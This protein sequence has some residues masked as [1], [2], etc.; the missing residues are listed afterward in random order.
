LVNPVPGDVIPQSPSTPTTIT[1]IAPDSSAWTLVAHRKPRS[2]LSVPVVIPTEP[3]HLP[4][5][6]KTALPSILEFDLYE[7]PEEPWNWPSPLPKPLPVQRPPDDLSWYTPNPTSI[8]TSSLTQDIPWQLE[9]EPAPEDPQCT[10]SEALAKYPELALPALNKEMDKYFGIMAVCD[11]NKPI[12][13]ADIP[14]DALKQHQSIIVQPRFHAAGGIRKVG[15]RCVTQGQ[16][17]PEHTYHSLYAGTVATVTRFATAAAYQARA[18]ATATPL[19][20]FSLDIPGAFLQEPLTELN[21]PVK[22]YIKFPA[23]IPHPCAGNWY[24]RYK[25]TYGSK[26]AN[27]LFADGFVATLNSAGYFPN[28]CD[29]KLF[30][31]FHPTDP[32]LSCSLC[33]HVDDGEGWSNYQPFVE[34]LHAALNHRYGEI[35]WHDDPIEQTGFSIDRFTDGSIA[36]GM[37]GFIAKMLKELGATHLPYRA[38]PSDSD[39]FDAPTDLTPVSAAIT[40]KIMGNL[41]YI[42]PVFPSCKKEFQYLSTRQATPTQSDLNKMI[43]LLAYINCH[44]QD[45]QVRFSG[46]DT[47]VYVHCDA[48]YA[49]HPGRS[50]TGYYIS[51]GAASGAIRS[52]S[53]KQTH[54]VADGSMAAEYVVLA[55]ATKDALHIRRM[56]HAAGFPQHQPVTVFED[57]EACIKLAEAPAITRH[58]EHIHVRYHLIR[59]FIA[60]GSVQIEYVTT[61]NQPADLLTKSLPPGLTKI[62]GD[63][64]QGT[65]MTPLHSLRPAQDVLG[66]GGSVRSTVV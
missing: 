18:K 65:S 14:T 45:A 57:N 4:R 66:V 26:N 29:E 17:Q 38:T 8:P 12:R 61:A 10:F 7:E 62:F 28:P 36:Y 3:L 25:G 48:S 60:N 39:L 58:S 5:T 34:E 47:Q 59:D 27:A 56:L 50:H 9:P 42:S 35:E 43:K 55:Q 53:A 41:T 21:S 13:F 15:V 44:Q 33:V 37:K 49:A 2:S 63:R 1:Q 20:H 46:S 31:R 40:R 64:I 19:H 24:Q 52:Y 54:C 23:N 30:T 16:H 22:C 11:I 32:S 6:S 51:I